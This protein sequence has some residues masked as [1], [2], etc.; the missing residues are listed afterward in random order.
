M[1]GKHDK[2]YKHTSFAKFDCPRRTDADFRQMADRDHHQFI[3]DKKHGIRAPITPLVKLPID[4]I[5][6]FS[7]ADD[8]HLLYIGKY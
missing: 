1:D 2:K 5:K 3:G 6:A 8:L 7:V 4:M